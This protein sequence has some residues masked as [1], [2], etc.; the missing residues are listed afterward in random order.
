MK[1]PAQKAQE[2]GLWIDLLLTLM[3]K[4]LPDF[5][6]AAKSGTIT[7]EDQKD[8]MRRVSDIRTQLQVSG[9]FVGG[10]WEVTPT[11]PPTP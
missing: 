5:L 8:K 7:I 3:E 6:A 4:L 10:E 1:T 11:V 9:K 2:V